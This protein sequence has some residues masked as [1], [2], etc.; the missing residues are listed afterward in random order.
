[1]ESQKDKALRENYQSWFI[2]YTPQSHQLVNK[3]ID[4]KEWIYEE[5][6]EVLFLGAVN[7]GKSSIINA[8]KGEK[9]AKVSQ[10]RSKTQNM[11]RYKMGTHPESKYMLIDSPG[12]GYTPAPLR[13]KKEFRK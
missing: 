1:M 11:L 12:Y 3:L 7:S 6:L 9:V 4:G 13:V 8:V 5:E 2:D 10:K